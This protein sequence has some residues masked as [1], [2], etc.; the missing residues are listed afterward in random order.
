M[1]KCTERNI[2][3]LK[4]IHKSSKSRR[5]SFINNC[6][7]DNIA[8]ISEIAHNLLKGN[9]EL[10]KKD[11]NKLK[12]YKGK[13]RKL[14]SQRTSTNNKK[15]IIQQGG[16]LPLLLSPFLAGVGAIAGRALATSLGL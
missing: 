9:L 10:S 4:K 13:I 2:D 5:N 14:A 12:R 7:S 16:F 8:A 1:S 15:K 3:F 6:S 11:L